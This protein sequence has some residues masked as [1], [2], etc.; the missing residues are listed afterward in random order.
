MKKLLLTVIP[1]LLF[2]SFLAAQVSGQNTNILFHFFK[3]QEGKQAEYETVMKDYYGEIMKENIKNGCMQNWI[4]RRVLPGT[5]ASNYFT[6]VTVDVLNPE[7]TNYQCEEVTKETVFP[8][9]SEGMHNL[10][11][12]VRAKGRKVVYR[13]STTYVAGFNKNETIPKYAAFNFIKTNPGKLNDYK[14]MHIEYQKDNFMKYSNQPMWHSFVR[15]DP[16]VGGSEEWNYLT[17]D[18]YETME[19]KRD[20]RVNVPENLTKEINKKYGNYLDLRDL[21]YQV[22]TELIMA[23]KE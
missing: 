14:N 1:L 13:T 22:V 7:K 20:R 3:V 8:E 21:K 9:M 5:N 11:R 10:L 23:A 17:I 15:S 12:N 16:R 18:G 19:Q 2:T 4:F 6:H